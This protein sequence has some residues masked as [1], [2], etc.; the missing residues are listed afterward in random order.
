MSPRAATLTLVLAS[1]VPTQPACSFAC[2]RPGLAA[3]AGH[4]IGQRD[5]AVLVTAPSCG[6]APTHRVTVPGESGSGVYSADGALLGVVI[7]N[8]SGQCYADTLADLH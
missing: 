5:P 2:V 6:N 8:H 1:C 7:E 4:C 3:T